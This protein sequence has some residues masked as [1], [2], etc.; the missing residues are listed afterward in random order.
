[1]NEK[2]NLRLHPLDGKEEFRA[3]ANGNP[4]WPL[5]RYLQMQHVPARNELV[6]FD[7]N[8]ITREAHANETVIVIR[9]NY[10]KGTVTRLDTPIIEL[11][12]RSGVHLLPRSP[13]AAK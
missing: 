4:A 1:M 13:I 5:Y 11:F 2:Q 7:H 10:K 3:D 8:K 6:I 12:R 9:W